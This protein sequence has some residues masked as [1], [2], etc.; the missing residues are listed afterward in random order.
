MSTS[1][2]TRAKKGKAQPSG[3]SVAGHPRAQRSI[4]MA[5]SYAG[6]GA[7][8]F[9]GYASWHAGGVFIDVATRALL[10]GTAA[11]VLVWALG[12]QVWRHLAV[13]EIRALERRRRELSKAPDPEQ[14]AKLAKA[15]ED[16]GMP[17]TG[18]PTN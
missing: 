7:F 10:W 18:I 8:L 5:K 16:S 14:V 15:L 4:R 6:M 3:I 1:R 17:T 2:K 13:A 12:V 9:A 11:Y